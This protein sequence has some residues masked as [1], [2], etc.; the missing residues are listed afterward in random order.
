MFS[1]LGQANREADF[2]E[3][4]GAFEHSAKL[5]TDTAEQVASAGGSANRHLK[6]TIKS[7]VL[8]VKKLCCFKGNGRC[9]IE[10]PVVASGGTSGNCLVYHYIAEGMLTKKPKKHPQIH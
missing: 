8:E 6:D 4:A 7:K 5:M 9:Y 1:I 2:E 10:K 3:K